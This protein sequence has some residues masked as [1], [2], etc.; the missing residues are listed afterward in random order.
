MSQA[1]S[2]N[3]SSRFPRGP[4]G[5]PTREQAEQRHRALLD[6]AAR[7]FIA[8]GL[9]GVSLE[10][11]AEEAAV[12]KRFVYARYRDKSELFVDAVRRLI[13]ERLSFI[14]MYDVGTAPVE[15]GLVA[16][17]ERLEA[18]A[19]RPES[20][21]LY[22]LVV[23]E[24]DRFPALNRLFADKT[25]ETILGNVTRVLNVYRERGEID[26]TDAILMTDLFVT[27]AVQGPRG[28]VLIGLISTPAEKH[29]RR[30][31][32]VRL[33]LDGCRAPKRT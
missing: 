8:H 24:L 11:I 12:A 25:R 18:A 1:K 16:F 31:A 10:A 13:E 3:N 6:A 28:R 23:T 27:L 4:G 20:L 22:R 21:A 14:G 29:R 7:L 2:A 33:F 5:R 30:K 19:T 17:A 9:N 32:V 26:F 15:A